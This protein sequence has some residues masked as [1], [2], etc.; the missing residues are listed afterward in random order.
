MK[1]PHFFAICTT[2]YESAY[3]V[4]ASCD[5]IFTMLDLTRIRY[6]SQAVA[7]AQQRKK[8]TSAVKYSGI[9]L[10]RTV[11]KNIASVS[12]SLCQIHTPF[13]WNLSL[14]PAA[15]RIPSLV[16]LGHLRHHSCNMWQTNLRG[17]CATLGPSLT[18]ASIATLRERV[19]EG[20]G[21]GLFEVCIHQST[22]CH[23]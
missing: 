8:H 20:P 6:F 22:R 18:R 12:Y 17:L 3:S 13:P 9:A 1:F 23:D 19:L 10:Q 2:F 16:A 21:D 7:A 14:R 11:L 5:D 15:G 4:P